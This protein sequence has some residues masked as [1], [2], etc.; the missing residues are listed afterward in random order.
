MLLNEAFKLGVAHEYTV[1]SMK[2]SLVRLRW[3][4]FE[5][6]ALA[7]SKPYL[8]YSMSSSCSSSGDVL[9]GQ[10]GPQVEGRHPQ[11]SNLPTLIDGRVLAEV[12]RKNKYKEPKKIP[13]VVPIFEPGTPSWS[14]YEYSSTP[15]NLSPEVEVTYPWEITIAN[16]VPDF[17]VH[18]MAKTKSTPR[19]RSSDELLASSSS[20]HSLRSSSSKEASTSSSPEA[21]PGPGES[22]LKRK[23]R[24]PPVTEIVVEGSEFLGAPTRSDPQ[25]DPGSHFADPKV[26]PK[27]KRSALE[28]QYLLPAEYSFVIPEADATVNEPPTE[29]IAVYR[30]AVNYGLC[31]PLHSVIKEILNKYE[32]TPAQKAPKET[33][34]LGWY[35]FNNR[36]GFMMAIEKK[37]KVKEPTADER[38]TAYYFQFY[39]RE[40]DRPR[41]IPR[42]IAQAIE[43]VKGPEK[44][45]NQARARLTIFETGDATPEQVATDAERRR[46]EERQLLIAEQAKKAPSLMPRRKRPD[47]SMAIR[48]KQRTEGQP[49]QTGASA[50]SQV[51]EA[52]ADRPAAHQSGSRSSG[53]RTPARQGHHTPSRTAGAMTPVA[54]GASL[55]ALRPSA[56]L[57]KADSGVRLS[58][59]QDIVKSWDLAAPRTSDPP[60]VSEEEIAMAEVFARGVR[61]VAECRW[62]EGPVSRYQRHCER[63]QANLE[64]RETEKKELQRQLEKAAANAIQAKEQGYQQGCSDTLGYLHK[65]WADA[66]RRDPEEV[67]FIPPSSEG[68][69]AGDEA[70]NPL[71]A[72]AGA[73]EEEE[74]EDGGEPDM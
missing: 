35:C 70:T 69:A 1:E 47:V 24:A 25:D 52:R 19:I 46:E 53:E 71:E 54:S 11:F 68:E 23:V 49:G 13:Y 9:E 30:A 45:R 65:A 50:P 15:S 62:L 28:K 58:L 37:S 31:F 4:T 57:I 36:S 20:G 29:C 60:K 39:I 73:S 16:Y 8:L 56:N 12:P 32:L 67:E 22:V 3:S 59:I 34:D 63:L 74:H 7:L 21:L 40:D 18:R 10:A 43:S 42:F 61:A 33:G 5:V 48:K 66:E 41:S 64:A 72:E 38:Q 17:Q 51:G 6:L 55:L 2:S 44:T 14:S 26:V 27:Q